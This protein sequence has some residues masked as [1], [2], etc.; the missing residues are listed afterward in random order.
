MAVTTTTLLIAAAV[1]AAGAAVQQ[2]QAAKK[3]AE[4]TA[5]T[6]RQQAERERQIAASNERDFR[7]QQSRLMATRRAVL[8]ASGVESSTGSALLATE[9]FAAESELQALK[10]RAGGETNATRLEQ[11]AQLQQLKGQNAETA[12]YFRAGSLLVGGG[13]DSGAFGK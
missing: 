7:R 11:S 3:Q 4:F 1:V 12:G 6:Q 5:A 10:I 13:M 9:D 2:G 8:G